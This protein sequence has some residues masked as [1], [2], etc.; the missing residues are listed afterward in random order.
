MCKKLE[1][2]LFSKT[3]FRVFVVTLLLLILVG[4]ALNLA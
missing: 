2:C 3:G 1:E 4:V